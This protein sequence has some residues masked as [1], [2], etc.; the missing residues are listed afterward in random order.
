MNANLLKNLKLD[1]AMSFEPLH[2]VTVYL[3]HLTFCN[4]IQIG[5][6]IFVVLFNRKT[7]KNVN[8]Y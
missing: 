5:A 6:V 1:C 3:N 7:N 8:L 4:I 2:C